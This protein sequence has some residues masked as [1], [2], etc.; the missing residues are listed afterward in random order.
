MCNHSDTELTV[1]KNLECSD[2]WKKPIFQ[3][4]SERYIK[5]MANVCFRELQT[6]PLL[7]HQTRFLD[8]ILSMKVEFRRA[9]L[10]EIPS[11]NLELSPDI[12]KQ[13]LT[14][15]CTAFPDT[16][17][18]LIWC[19]RLLYNTFDYYAALFDKKETFLSECKVCFVSYPDWAL[20]ECGHSLCIDC[21]DKVEI[22]P[23]CRR[24]IY[25]HVESIDVQ[26]LMDTR[27]RRHVN[28]QGK[29]IPIVEFLMTNRFT[30][31]NIKLILEF[32]SDDEKVLFFYKCVENSLNVSSFSKKDIMTCFVSFVKRNPP[33]FEDFLMFLSRCNVRKKDWDSDLKNCLSCIFTKEQLHSLEMVS[34]G[35]YY[36]P[37]I[38]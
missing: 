32:L 31:E 2:C 24:D 37:W 9:F 14:I 5:I 16:S 17:N 35:C 33:I 36:A 8:L 28:Y 34:L 22:C 38:S 19:S 20:L 3:V 21:I 15:I 25:Y 29:N 11:T 27:K 13:F 10:S 30:L 1:W 6:C 4:G 7:I 12:S 26:Q 23:F 18:G